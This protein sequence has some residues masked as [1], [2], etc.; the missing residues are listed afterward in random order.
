MAPFC[1]HRSSPVIAGVF[2]KGVFEVN[3]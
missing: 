1:H 3:D 2:Y